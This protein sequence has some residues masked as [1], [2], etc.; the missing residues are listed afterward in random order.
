MK[1]V[2]MKFIMKTT[3]SQFVLVPVTTLT[4]TLA[5][6]LTIL[7]S[8]YAD[9]GTVALDKVIAIVNNEAITRSEYQ[10]RYKRQQL[11]TNRGA[12][13]IPKQ[14]NDEI[15]ELLIDER[16]QVQAAQVAGISIN[17]A[18]IENELANIAAQNNF[19]QE[20]LITE[21]KNQGISAIQFSRSIKEQSLIQR[22]IDI[23]VNSRITVSEQE[24]D[25]YL[26]AHKER[27]TLDQAYEISHLYVSTSG[28]SEAEIESESEN[29]DYIY[30]GLLQ[31]Q[32]F[33]K[34]VKDF[35]DGENK[36]DG[37]Y[38]G[39]RKEQQLP[40][41][42]L[43]ALRQTPVGGVTEIMKSANGFHIIK[44]HAKK[45]DQKI[46][47]QQLVRHILLQPQQSNLTNQE[48]IDRLND[49]LNKIREGE[50]FEKF[51]RLIS[52]DAATAS[53]GGS[54]GWI[55]PGDTDPMFEQAALNLPMNQLSNPVQSRFGYHLIEVLDRREK[56][57][58][59]DIARNSAQKELFKRKAVERYQNWFSRLREGAYIE[60]VSSN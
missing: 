14:I 50:D 16:I 25:Y 7:F 26:Q 47:A 32:S 8:P 17:R 34:A 36:N 30:Q 10:T 9:A 33:S 12:E 21:L 28:K 35:S 45:G 20:Q 31:G 58:S 55:N 43:T 15:L 57:I 11:E 52:D 54:L 53:Q 44:L 5:I 22:L 60:Y 40:E 6:T 49:V 13:P 18:E 42:F 56:D 27:Y 4:A 41:L 3:M 48:A 51:A 38:M 29:V 39:W 2:T 23:S 59:R 24:I 1:L 46:V 37:G 19:S